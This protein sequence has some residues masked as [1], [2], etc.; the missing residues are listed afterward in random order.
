MALMMAVAIVSGAGVIATDDDYGEEKP[1][2]DVDKEEVEKA[3]DEADEKA[4]DE[5]D[6]KADDKADEK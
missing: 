5:A 4:D 1:E 2:D 3:D 6:E